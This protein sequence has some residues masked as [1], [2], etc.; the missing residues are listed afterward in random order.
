VKRGFP[1]HPQLRQETDI[2]A[3]TQE[4][5][6]CVKEPKVHVD[7]SKY[8]QESHFTFD[9]AFHEQCSNQ[10]SRVSCRAAA[11]LTSGRR[12]MTGPPSLSCSTCFKEEERR[13][14]RMG[15]QG[16]ALVLG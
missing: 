14:L 10:V 6:V 12:C 11:L 16:F 3:V 2:V 15:R 9:E 8:T 13:V 7:M 1:R 4:K 5:V